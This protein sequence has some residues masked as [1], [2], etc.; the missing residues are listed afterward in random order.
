MAAGEVSFRLLG[1]G[2][3]AEHIVVDSLHKVYSGIPAIVDR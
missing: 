2:A 1:L 3:L